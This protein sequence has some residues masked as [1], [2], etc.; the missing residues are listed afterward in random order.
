[1]Q[2]LNDNTVMQ[3]LHDNPVM[4]FVSVKPGTNFIHDYKHIS[5][6][7]LRLNVGKYRNSSSWKLVTSKQPPIKQ[8]NCCML[9]TELFFTLNFP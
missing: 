6:R 1:M 4:Q 2:L 5:R 3:L 7:E 9:Q 8:W